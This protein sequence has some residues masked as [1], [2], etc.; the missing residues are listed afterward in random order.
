MPNRAPDC[1]VH[2]TRSQRLTIS[3]PTP[4]SKPK[5]H[6]RVVYIRYG[7]QPITEAEVEIMRLHLDGAISALKSLDAENDD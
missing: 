3:Y 2:S 4:R 7:E 6:R 1:T 5:P